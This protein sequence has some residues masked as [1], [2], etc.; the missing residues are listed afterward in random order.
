MSNYVP[1]ALASWHWGI[2]SGMTH[3][4]IC[5]LLVIANALLLRNPLFLINIYGIT[6]TVD[7]I[8][9]PLW[10][11]GWGCFPWRIF[12]GIGMRTLVDEITGVSEAIRRKNY[13]RGRLV[14]GTCWC[15]I[16]QSSMPHSARS[17]VVLLSEGTLKQLRI[18]P[19]DWT[20]GFSERCDQIGKQHLRKLMTI[21]W[22]KCECNHNT[23]QMIS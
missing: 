15:R 8:G 2:F 5:S 22:G 7:R 18:V 3:S 4:N 19:L 9:F 13:L 1:S 17:V 16:I 23:F 12:G 10:A 21:T 14:R 11:T 6:R 20:L